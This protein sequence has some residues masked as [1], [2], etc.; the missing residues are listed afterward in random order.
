MFKSQHRKIQ[1]SACALGAA[2]LTAITLLAASAPP[3]NAAEAAAEPSTHQQWVQQVEA[4]L[5]KTLIYP[6][7]AMRS[8]K[9]GLARVAV[10]VEP[11]GTV[12]DVSLSN[13]TGTTSL[14]RAAVRAVERL[15]KL[16]PVPGADRPQ[17][18]VLQVGFGIAADS[19]QEV[20]LAKS[21]KEVPA[22]E[23]AQAAPRRER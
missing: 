2:G 3:V 11:D 13:S 9:Q 20:Q 12:R 14:D 5:D 15:G 6:H 8:G 10:M 16:P 1:R 18:V 23:Y 7:A 21:F 22:V 19:R 17:Y 4:R